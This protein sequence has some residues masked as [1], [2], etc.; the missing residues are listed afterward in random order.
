MKQ[1]K[2]CHLLNS[3]W[4]CDYCVHTVCS[5]TMKR[6]FSGIKSAST[7]TQRTRSKRSLTSCPSRL[8]ILRPLSAPPAAPAHS[9]AAPSG[10]LVAARTPAH[11]SLPLPPSLAPRVHSQDSLS[12]QNNPNPAAPWRPPQMF[13]PSPSPPPPL[14]ALTLLQLHKHKN[15]H[16]LIY[17]GLRQSF[18]FFLNSDRSFH[19]TQHPAVKEQH[20]HS[21]GVTLCPPGESKP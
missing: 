6:Y 10:S 5:S 7:E 12:S 19:L 8:R 15:N 20:N 16:S 4:L 21:S 18:L 13:P 3:P 11:G 14:L 2:L 1:P 17:R 9:P